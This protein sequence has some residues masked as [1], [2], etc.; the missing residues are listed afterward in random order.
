[1]NL[2]S[3]LKGKS[4]SN[5][6]VIPIRETMHEDQEQTK[7][8]NA[9]SLEIPE[10]LFVEYEAPNKNKMDKT[11]ENREVHTIQVLFDFLGQNLE[12]KGYEDALVNP[13]TSYMDEHVVYIQNDLS[14]MI[15][16]VK[17]YYSAYIRTVN[18][19]IETRK[20]NGLIET[21]DELLAHK[22]SIEEDIKKVEEI[23]V[24]SKTSAGL[25]QNIV[26][27]YKR[28]FRNGFAAITYNNVLGKKS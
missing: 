19:H 18:F 6:P 2:M 14:L 7:S 15:A 27:S 3:L 11:E 17:T 24:D 8:N 1:M 4:V 23:E 10:K 28:G 22:Q 13:D 21:V 26:L 9:S 12:R 5:V 20:R 16:R 25:T